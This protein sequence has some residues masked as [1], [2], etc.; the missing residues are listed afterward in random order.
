[1]R[2]RMNMVR[3]AA[4]SMVRV[5]RESVRWDEKRSDDERIRDIID[6]WVQFEHPQA[7]E[8]ISRSRASQDETTLDDL[9]ADTMDEMIEKMQRM[10]GML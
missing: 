10:A 3:V 8:S 2:G 7:W 4:K 6:L 9:S 5:Y 1:M